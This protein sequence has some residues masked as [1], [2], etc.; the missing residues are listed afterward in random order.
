MA[1]LFDAVLSRKNPLFH[2]VQTDN[3]RYTD[4]GT[5]ELK[6]VYSTSA[7]LDLP[8]YAT[9]RTN[10]V[11]GGPSPRRGNA[12]SLRRTFE[13]QG[14]GAHVARKAQTA[15]PRPRSTPLTSARNFGPGAINLAEIRDLVPGS[16]VGNSSLGK[17]ISV[18]G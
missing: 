14:L 2:S 12:S 7:G 15:V 5:A 10:S 9:R 17:A 3:R 18:R 8:T 16:S 11:L 1:R 4:L 6:L 13:V